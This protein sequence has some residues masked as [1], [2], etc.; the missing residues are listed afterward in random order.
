MVGIEREMKQILRYKYAS[1]LI[2]I[3]FVI[4][5]LSFVNG[6]KI[7]SNINQREKESRN[8]SYISRSLLNLQFSPEEV[9]LREIE[10][11]AVE[12]FTD[13]EIDVIFS[14]VIVNIDDAGVMVMGDVLLDYEWGN[15]YQLIEG[16]LPSEGKV[17]VAIGRNFLKACYESKGR[18]Y[19]SID[20]NEYVVSG[21]I[22]TPNTN[23]QDNKVVFSGEALNQI[24]QRNISL[25]EISLLV[26]SDEEDVSHYV[27][28][29]TGKLSKE[30]GVNTE[31]SSEV[32]NSSS[33]EKTMAMLYGGI[34]IFCILNLFIIGELWLFVRKKEI[35][36]RRAFGYSDKEL[37]RLIFTDLLKLSGLAALLSIIIQSIGVRF[38]KF[39]KYAGD[40]LGVD[41]AIIVVLGAVITSYIVSKRMICSTKDIKDVI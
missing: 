38:L 28:G 5:I 40:T 21:V 14:Q 36:I 24:C 13:K 29:L 23:I 33:G 8:Y 16:E 7:V 26:G 18:R 1:I 2:I 12:Y 25:G 9:E 15:V 6:G 31:L 19:I 32:I 35:A 11:I 22:G 4:A 30:Q 41:G 17:E 27:S 34:Y 37:F 39:G 3:G 20:G 10:R